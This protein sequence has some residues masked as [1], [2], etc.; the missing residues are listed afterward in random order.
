VQHGQQHHR[1]WL[2]EVQR[3]RRLGQDLVGV[4]EVGVYVGGPPLG[5]AG[6][7]RAG[8]GQDDGIVVH[9]HDPRLLVGPLGHLV[10]VVRGGQA[11]ATMA[12]VGMTSG[13]PWAAARSAAKLSLPPRK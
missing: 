10:G 5:P 8:V 2:A 11:R 12:M 3:P 13:T 4:A 7:Q 6:Q 1:D 9:V